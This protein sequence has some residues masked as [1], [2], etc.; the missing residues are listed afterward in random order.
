MIDVTPIPDR[1]KNRVAQTEYQKVLCRLFA[2]IMIDSVNLMFLEN[3][4]QLAIQ[5]ACRSQIMSERLF[6]DYP[7]PTAILFA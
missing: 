3:R 7:A 5:F 2:K 6:D 4:R 1:L